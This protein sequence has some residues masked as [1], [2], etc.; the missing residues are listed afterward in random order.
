M[1][2]WFRNNY[3]NITLNTR[4]KTQNLWVRRVSSISQSILE[5]SGCFKIIFHVIEWLMPDL[6]H[7]GNYTSTLFYKKPLV[8]AV[9]FHWPQ[10]G[11]NWSWLL[12]G[13]NSIKCLVYLLYLNGS[14][15]VDVF[16]T[17]RKNMHE[18]SIGKA[19]LLDNDTCFLSSVEK[20]SF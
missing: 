5:A 20:R 3:F 13:I 6:T 12:H 14:F 8:H 17:K 10:V 1:K 11:L 19:S 15:C 4:E 16:P 18:L 9:N 7:F 2:H